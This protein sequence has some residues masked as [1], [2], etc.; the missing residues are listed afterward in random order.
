MMDTM[1]LGVVAALVFLAWRILHIQKQRGTGCGN[2][3]GCS[4][5]CPS[6][7]EQEGKK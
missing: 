1:V 3:G 2:C 5:A 6:R 7:R 4:R